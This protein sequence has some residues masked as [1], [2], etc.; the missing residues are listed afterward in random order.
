MKRGQEI[1][2]TITKTHRGH[3]WTGLSEDRAT[4]E[5]FREGE[6]YSGFLYYNHGDI[7]TI[8]TFGG[9]IIIVDF[10]SLTVN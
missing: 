6:T 3:N 8:K 4:S 2:V 5:I 9:N 10:K 1:S 7:L